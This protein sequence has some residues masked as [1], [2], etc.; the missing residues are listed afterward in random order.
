MHGRAEFRGIHKTSLGHSQWIGAAADDVPT[1]TIAVGCSCMAQTTVVRTCRAAPQARTLLQPL[2][3]DE[4]PPDSA[5]WRRLTCVRARAH[6]LGTFAPG[7]TQQP[8]QAH[9][10]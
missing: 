2:G 1:M 9:E 10:A 8:H 7:L 4:M 6:G 5:L 3:E